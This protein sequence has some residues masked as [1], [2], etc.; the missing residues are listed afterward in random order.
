MFD[1]RAHFFVLLTCRLLLV[2]PTGVFA[3]YVP[4]RRSGVVPE[5]TV[6]S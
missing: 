3:S 1:A 6:L 5:L 2:G 4:G